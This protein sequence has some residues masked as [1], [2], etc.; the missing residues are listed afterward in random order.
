MQL[1]LSENIKKYRKDMDLTQEGLA[2]ALGVTVGAVSKWENGNNVPDV[3]TMMEL[4][5]FFN[6]SMDEL[7]GFSLSSKKIEDMCKEIDALARSH[8]FDEG[9]LV[10]KDAMARYPH[11]F[12]VLYACADLYYYKFLESKD[13]KDSEDAIEIFES[14]L[15]YISQSKEREI[16]EYTVKTKMAYLYRKID[17]GKAIELL[18]KTNYEGWRCNEIGVVFMDM[19]KTKEALENFSIALLKIFTEQLTTVNNIAEALMATGKRSDI[20]SATDLVETELK[21][22]SDYGIPGEV[23]VTYKLRALL[24]VLMAY[25]QSFLDKPD[26]MEEYVK[27]ALDLA[28]CFDEAKIGEDFIT[29]LRYNYFSQEKVKAY[30]ASGT[31]A[32]DSIR[33]MIEK[34]LEETPEHNK[35]KISRV[36][37]CWKRQAD[38]AD[39]TP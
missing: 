15:N 37:D 10:V 13:M 11:T 18:K 6:I 39:D 17:P 35:E 34:K 19:G 28:I 31:K 1:K 29:G 9:I 36:L 3:M 23:N 26:K 7:L 38:K 4:A 21:I 27:E 16:M 12:K 2:D 30:D 5:D 14:A 24:C 32:I 22:V 8:R 20:K 25:L 33:T